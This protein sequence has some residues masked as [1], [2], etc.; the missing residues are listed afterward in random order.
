MAAERSW[1]ISESSY[2]IL[3]AAI[4]LHCWLFLS[5]LSMEADKKS[6]DAPLAFHTGSYDEYFMI[7]TDEERAEYRELAEQGMMGPMAQGM[8]GSREDEASQSR[9][10]YPHLFPCVILRSGDGVSCLHSRREIVWW[11][12]RARPHVLRHVGHIG[13][14]RTLNSRR[15]STRDDDVASAPVIRRARRSESVTRKRGIILRPAAAEGYGCDCEWLG[16]ASAAKHNGKWQSAGYDQ[17]GT[18]CCAARRRW[19]EES[20]ATS[21]A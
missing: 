9:L 14:R 20:K 7:V 5:S 15:K 8:M 11:S 17:R 4:F 1:R 18:I 19:W 12:C 3:S 10:R 6:P 2:A 16:S 21:A 13:S